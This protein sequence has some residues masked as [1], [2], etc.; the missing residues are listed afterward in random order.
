M[1]SE[2]D[3]LGIAFDFDGVLVRSNELKRECFLNVAELYRDPVFE[4]FE[5][6]CERNPG[7]T[8]FQKMRW[9]EAEL[10][11]TGVDVTRAEL[12]AQYAYCVKTNLVDTERVGDLRDLKRRGPD[13]PWSIVSSAPGD[14]L[15]WFLDRV[16][17]RDLF[18]DGIYGTPRTKEAIFEDEYDASDRRRLLFL[19][20]SESDLAVARE[21]GLD[22][23]FISQ[24]SRDPT[25]V[26]SE[27][28]STV[29][30]VVDFFRD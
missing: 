4:R 30:S 28:V 24:W 20:D 2:Y 11:E 27:D 16:G 1:I 12:I 18:E 29:A 8:R 10:T 26:D 23:V 7:D 13:V 22:F 9:L 21:F 19:G 25:V 15:R 17:W 14:E 3:P 6:Y 5:E